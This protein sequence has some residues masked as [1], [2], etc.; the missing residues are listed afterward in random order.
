MDMTLTA[1]FDQQ[2]PYYSDT[3][4][5]QRDRD[6]EAIDIHPSLG[7]DAS[8]LVNELSHDVTFDCVQNHLG[9]LAAAYGEFIDSSMN[10]VHER[11]H[12]WSIVYLA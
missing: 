12:G 6:L 1:K 7:R 3:L 11:Q 8:Y 10:D 5:K 2:G 9:R 4:P